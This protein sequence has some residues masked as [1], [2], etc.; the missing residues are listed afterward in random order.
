M[1]GH[2]WIDN[3]GK[4]IDEHV[5]V[6]D[7]PFHPDGD[8]VCLVPVRMC[9]RHGMALTVLDGAI[10]GVIALWVGYLGTV[11]INNLD[12]WFTPFFHGPF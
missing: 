10:I 1:K 6:F 2:L 11:A 9:P 4:P 8:P 5:R 12:V 3:G 7:P